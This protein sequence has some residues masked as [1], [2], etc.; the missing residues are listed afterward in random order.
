MT[1]TDEAISL[2][3]RDELFRMLLRPHWREEV[4]SRYGRPDLIPD[5]NMILGL[6]VFSTPKKVQSSL[7][8][9][10]PHWWLSIRRQIISSGLLNSEGLLT[11]SEISALASL[12]ALKS[13]PTCQD[14]PSIKPHTSYVLGFNQSTM[15]GLL[16]VQWE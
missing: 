15:P 13:K 6:A 16:N 2:N 8:M 7:L 9:N 12:Y 1:R 4:C 14:K 11:S 3:G 10:W 5:A